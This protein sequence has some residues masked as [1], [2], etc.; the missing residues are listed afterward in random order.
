MKISQI[1]KYEKVW[2]KGVRNHK[3][4]NWKQK[5]KE[6]PRNTKITVIGDPKLP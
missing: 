4:Q 3:A 2:I 5:T 1:E 6:A